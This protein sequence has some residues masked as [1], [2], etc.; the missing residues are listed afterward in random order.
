MRAT[1]PHPQRVFMQQRRKS[2][3]GTPLVRSTSTPNAG[4][5][6]TISGRTAWDAT[7][8]S[9]RGQPRARAGPNR[10]SRPGGPVALLGDTRSDCLGGGSPSQRRGVRER[11]AR[12][13]CPEATVSTL[14]QPPTRPRRFA[15]RVSAALLH[16]TRSARRYPGPRPSCRQ[17]VE[18]PPN[19]APT[20]G[21]GT[22]RTR[23]ALRRLELTPVPRSL[24]RSAQC[25]R[26]RR[27]P[28]GGGSM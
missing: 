21:T 15:Q 12:Q 26:R 22:D 19:R 24:G 3:A 28:V 4:A 2:S 6:L 13:A 9:R 14:G 20:T 18:R 17:P 8:A 10:A 11:A 7:V 27:L 1:P 23:R 16:H 25:R 5:P